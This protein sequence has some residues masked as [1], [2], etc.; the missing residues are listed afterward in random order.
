MN[1]YLIILFIGISFYAKAFHAVLYIST[2][3][4]DAKIYINNEL[5]GTGNTVVILDEA[6]DV[7]VKV[8]MKGFESQTITYA[9]DEHKSTLTRKNYERGDNKIVIELQKERILS[10]DIGLAKVMVIDGKYIFT[11]CEPIAKYEIVFEFSAKAIS[12]GCPDVKQIAKACINGANKKGLPYDAV[13]V[14]TEKYD[15]AIRFK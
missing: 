1:K 8:E 9:Y 15:I 10:S 7:L 6:K 12:A 4:S 13:I 14:G 11:N 2:N 5:K 3:P